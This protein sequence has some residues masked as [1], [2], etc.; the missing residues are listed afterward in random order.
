VHLWQPDSSEYQA[1]Q[2][3]LI[4]LR[5]IAKIKPST[6]RYRI[7]PSRAPLSLDDAALALTMLEKPVRCEASVDEST[8]VVAC[9]PLQEP[10]SLNRRRHLGVRRTALWEGAVHQRCH[11]PA[12]E[13]K[14]LI[15]KG[16]DTITVSFEALRAW[17][18]DYDMNYS[19]GLDGTATPP[20]GVCIV[21]EVE[22]PGTIS[23]D[24]DQTDSL[25]P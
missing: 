2:I 20:L 19:L 3:A 23:V 13:A 4:T 5:T 15:H 10:Q 18:R 25:D 14:I 11:G 21:L 1:A 22:P 17:F 7:L 16:E 24:D 9:R 8:L 12:R 6:V